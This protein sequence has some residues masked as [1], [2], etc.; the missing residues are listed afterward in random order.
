MTRGGPAGHTDVP[1]TRI[2]EY[3]AN[4]EFGYSTAM[5]VIFGIVLLVIS[6]FQIEASRRMNK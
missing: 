2:Y 6:A 5:A 4:G 1:I 3:M